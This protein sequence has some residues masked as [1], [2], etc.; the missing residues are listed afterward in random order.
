MEI[1]VNFAGSLLYPEKVTYTSGMSLVFLFTEA[2]RIGVAFNPIKLRCNECN[3]PVAELAGG[4]IIIRNR[5]HGTKHTTSIAIDD[6]Q[7]ITQY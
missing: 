5:H 4:S 1:S 6:L 3:T 2:S 7:N